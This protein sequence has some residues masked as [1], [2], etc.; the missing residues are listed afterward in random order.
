M[1]RKTVACYIRRLVNHYKD[2]PCLIYKKAFR[3]ERLLYWDVYNYAHMVA[4]F[5]KEKGLKKGDKI[6]IYCY[7]C[8]EWSA[9]LLACALSGVIAVP[10]D[11][12]S[13]KEFVNIIAKKVNS[14]LV[15]CSRFKSIN[16]NTNQIFVEDLFKHIKKYHKYRCKAN[17][18][19]EDI[20]EIVYTSGTTSNPKGVIITNKNLVSNIRS[21]RLN[22]PLKG[23]LVFLSVVPLSH[24]LEQTVGFFIPLRFGCKIVY[25]TSRKSSTLLEAMQEE[26]IT[27]MVGVPILLKTFKAKIER[28]VEKK[29]KTKIFEKS[30]KSSEK[31]PFFVRRIVF[32]KIINKLSP[33]FKFFIVGGAPLDENTENFWNF[34]GIMVLQG[35]G[36]T[37]TS[38]I[39]TC[40]TFK[41]HRQHTVGKIL[42]NQEIKISKDEEILCKGENITKGYYKNQKATKNSIKNGWFYTG[43]LGEFDKNNFL[44]LKGRKK[45]IILTSSG[46]NVYPEDIEQ[47]LDAKNTIKGSV[48]LGIKDKK[49]IIIT[50]VVLPET[51]K[52]INTQKLIK[53][54]NSNLSS[55]QQLQKILIWP[56]KDFPRT[57][58]LKIKRR[59]VEQYL[60][61]S[62]K[63]GSEKT[64]ASNKIFEI[65]ASLSNINISKIKVRSV[66]STDL[67]IDSL[68]RVELLSLIEERY[69]VEIEESK[70]TEKTTVDELL[71][72]I[73]KSSISLSNIVLS[74]LNISYIVKPLRYFFQIIAFI[75]LRIFYNVHVVGKEKLENIKGPVIFAINHTS[76]LDTITL[77]RVLPIK[78]KS[79]IAFA[80]AQDYFFVKDDDKNKF[81]KKT[82]LIF[83][84][85]ILNIFPFS[86]GGNIKQ[87]LKLTGKLLDKG[88]SI[89]IY[90]EGTRSIN[91]EIGTF[92][93]GIGLIA[94]NMKVPIVPVKIKGLFD[95][96]PK[97][98]KFPCFGKT[99]VYFGKPIIAGNRESYIKIARDIE[100]A[101]KKL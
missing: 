22:M 8:P 64:I 80:A 5:F 51:N 58:S 73:E 97:G 13:K 93:L 61:N 30:L 81:W 14:K 42:P 33:K 6:I 92:K 87:S 49:D 90:P 48:V 47:V 94:S 52:K 9:I 38:P 63:D 67:A 96:L 82:K 89:G 32:R 37:E 59:D 72:L 77:L 23:N 53:E 91:G 66:L 99:A 35:Y 70:I 74:S 16:S 39:M 71:K 25:T 75:I 57:P 21:L 55:Y 46:L 54:I 1:A 43:D 3:T 7:N 69:N 86:R 20:F 17:I 31:F 11:F 18:K 60:K 29:G 26:K 19:E 40:N 36:L 45:N 65:L 28:E 62:L 41:H 84:Q 2:R 50:A 15:F 83:L 24:L 98:K 56:M 68:H 78:I 88:I 10:I 95:I 34:L 79:N 12:N 44:M 100:N 85:I 27:S 101:V 4:G 76:H